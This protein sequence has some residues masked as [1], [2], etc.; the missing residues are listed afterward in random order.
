[1][2]NVNDKN[3]PNEQGETPLHY[4]AMAKKPDVCKHIL[5]SVEDKSPK[6]NNGLTPL[7]WAVRFGRCRCYREIYQLLLQY[8]K[9]K[10]PPDANGNTPLHYAAERNNLDFCRLVIG[11][12]TNK[13][14][15]N[16]VGKTP[17]HEA[18]WQNNM[19]FCQLIIENNFERSLEWDSYRQASDEGD[20][21]FLRQIIIESIEDVTVFW[22]DA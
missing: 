12:L 4:A 21:D 18:A 22:P 10:N 19:T 15:A 2:E 9:D 3:P 6:C 5:N 20:M 14:P 7:H 1:M 17:L 8:V 16:D 13:N 11:Q